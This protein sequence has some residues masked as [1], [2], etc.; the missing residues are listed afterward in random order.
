MRSLGAPSSKYPVFGDTPLTPGSPSLTLD[1]PAASGAQTYPRVRIHRSRISSSQWD[2]GGHK[3]HCP[4]SPQ[5]QPAGIQGVSG[6]AAG[7]RPGLRAACFPS[8]SHG[9]HSQ[10][11]PA[12]SPS[13][14][15]PNSLQQAGGLL[16][17]GQHPSSGEG[18]ASTSAENPRA[19]G[20]VCP[21][22]HLG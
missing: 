15:P 13:L 3:A 10:W 11:R 7:V 4:V 22:A 6:W 8:A 20:G 5:K 17:L 14:P 18:G 19:P 1:S 12:G 2:F 21:G 16:A 9:A